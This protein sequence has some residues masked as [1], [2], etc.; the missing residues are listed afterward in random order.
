[1]NKR[2]QNKRHI[3]KLISKALSGNLSQEEKRLLDDW[4]DDHEKKEAVV[5]TSLSKK[6]YKDRLYLNTLSKIK[7][8]K[9]AVE[10]RSYTHI[11]YIAASVLLCIGIGWFLSRGHPT[12]RTIVT[13][14]VQQFQTFENKKG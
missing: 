10:S 2:T 6:E 4:Y 12:N 11:V 8:K 13:P 3:R 1:M 9:K 5:F 7:P 14:N